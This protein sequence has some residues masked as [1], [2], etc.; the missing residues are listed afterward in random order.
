MTERGKLRLLSSTKWLALKP[1]MHNRNGLSRLYLYICAHI[2][3]CNNKNWRRRETINLRVREWARRGWGKCK[4][5]VEGGKEWG[6]VIQL[7]FNENVQDKNF[8]LLIII[9]DVFVHISLWMHAFCGV[10]VEME[11]RRS[12]SQ[13][14]RLS[15]YTLGHKDGS[16]VASQIYMTHVLPAEPS[17]WP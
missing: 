4:K 1:H 15:L 2:Y 12:L 3:V 6:K 13:M 11:A 9:I 7:Y 8:I 10:Y 17:W 14:K 5:K 16:Q